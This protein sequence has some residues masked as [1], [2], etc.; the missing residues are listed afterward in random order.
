MKPKGTDESSTTHSRKYRLR[1]RTAHAEY[2]GL[3]FSPHPERRLS[4]A[5][6][7]M[8]QF[9]NLKDVSDTATGETFPFVVI[10]RALI[11]TI[12]VIEEW[13]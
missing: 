5:L 6:T 13:S 4:E 7:R 1:I 12:K 11:E 2:E 3:F 9:I 8:E 10:N